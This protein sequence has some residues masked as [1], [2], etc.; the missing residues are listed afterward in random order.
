MAEEKPKNYEI[1]SEEMQDIL[2]KAPRSIVRYGIT[3]IFTVIM[4]VIAGSWFFK[5]PDTINAPIT[6]T[7]ENIPVTLVAK[8]S[9]KLNRLFI[10]DGDLVSKGNPLALIENNANYEQINLLLEQLQLLSPHTADFTANIS[11]DTL[12]LRTY[13]QLGDVQTSFTNYVKTLDEIKN[14]NSLN[15]H[16][17]KIKAVKEQ[18]AMTNLYYER[19]YAQC[20]LLENDLMLIQKQFRRDSSLFSNKVIAAS[21]YEKSESIFLQKKYALEGSKTALANTK[22]QLTQ[23]QQ[24][25]LDL[26]L[27]YQEQSKK[28]GQAYSQAYDEVLNQLHTWQQTYMLIASI[29]GKVS[30]T[31]FWAV[32]Q[33]IAIND[34]V[35]SIVPL[36]KSK[37]IGKL[38]LPL[39]GAGKVRV[40]QQVNIQLAGY[41]YLEYG[42]LI[43]VVNNISLVS[44]DNKYSL[45]ISLSDSLKTNYGIS[46]EMKSELQGTAEIITDDIRLLQ[47]ILNPI[48]SLLKKQTK[49]DFPIKVKTL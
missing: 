14:F 6:I 31:N 38:M 18:I 24:Q 22:I 4:I 35:M 2:G 36:G 23:L 19:Q 42:S 20:N 1:R 29:D 48:K 5:Y 47:R 13:N 27:Q 45:E 10:K 16:H 21:E 40:G 15:Y 49:T 44:S 12:K 39:E 34:K 26:Q 8:A 37:I 41:P 9:G 32:N 11:I 43:G 28:A 30:F 7:S 46:L 3:V 25:I 33:Q 17:Q